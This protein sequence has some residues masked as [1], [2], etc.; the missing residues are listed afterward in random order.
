MERY[1]KLTIAILSL[2][3]REALLKQLQGMDSLFESIPCDLRQNLCCFVSD[4]AS[5]DGSAEVLTSFAKQRAWFSYFIQPELVHYDINVLA[6][7]EK[8]NTDYIWLMAVD[9]YICSPENIAEIFRLLR[10]Y[11]PSGMVFAIGPEQKAFRVVKKDVEVINSPCD[12]LHAIEVGGGGKVSCNIIKKMG[13]LGR[14]HQKI[15]PFIGIGYMHS[16]LQAVCFELSKQKR[17]LRIKQQLVYSQQDK[18]NRYHPKYALNFRNSLAT[19]YFKENCPEFFRM[20]DD[21]RINSLKWISY[22]SMHRCL[23]CSWNREMLNDFIQ[24]TMRECLTPPFS[25]KILFWFL[26]TIFFLVPHPFFLRTALLAI[27]RVPKTNS[28]DYERKNP[29]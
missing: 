4:N 16:T 14:C 8:L 1:P 15:S 25:I 6:C 2:D 13:E 28:M 9:D 17:F 12:M 11:S 22:Q 3:N 20:L 27:V 18:K 23:V 29:I 26:V 5:N 7:Y 10:K 19:D 24:T 21:K